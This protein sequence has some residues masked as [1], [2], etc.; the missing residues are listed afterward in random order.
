MKISL[1]SGVLGCV[2][3]LGI[4]AC[5]KADSPR[6]PSATPST[7]TSPAPLPTE[8]DSEPAASWSPSLKQKPGSFYFGQGTLPNLVIDKTETA[9]AGQLV[10]RIECDRGKII[11]RVDIDGTTKTAT[12]PCRGQGKIEEQYLDDVRSGQHLAIREEGEAGIQ[13]A[14]ELVVRKKSSLP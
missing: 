2:V 5:D 6:R 11:A 3:M 4:G 13:F 1:L 12:F 14:L 8:S 7:I 10:L 9:T